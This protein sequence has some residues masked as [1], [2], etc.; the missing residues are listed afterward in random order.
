MP[1]YPRN[2][3][4]GRSL[5]AALV[6]ASCF[7]TAAVA[8]WLL[9][10]P[11]FS[12]AVYA[13]AVCLGVI[14]TFATLYYVDAYSVHVLASGRKTF[15]SVV[16][17][18]GVACLVTLLAHHFVPVP[19]GAASTAT[20]V[21]AL[22]FPL[23]LAGRLAFRSIS[24][25]RALTKR[26]LVIGA[27]ELGI[28]IAREMEENHSLGTELVGFLSDE[29]IYERST[30]EGLPVLGKLHH[31]E[32]VVDEEK[33]DHIVVASKNRGEHFPADQ[34][35][36]KKF[37]GLSIESGVSF[38]ERIS[39][40]V[41]MRDLRPSYL[42]FSEGFRVS[43]LS[44]LIKRTLDI[45]FSLTGLILSAPILA[46]CT[47]AICI[48]SRG[49]AFYGQ[50]R[51]GK[52]GKV[53]SVLKLRTM[54]PDA[55]ADTGPVW[56]REEDDRVTRVGRFLRMTRLDEVPQLW[57]V[58]K[59][60]MTLVG[61]RP[62][63]PEFVD[64]LSE[65]YPYF[66]LR[67]TLKPGITGWAQIRRGYVNEVEGFEEKLALDIYYMKYRSTLMDLLILWKTAKTVVLMSG[68]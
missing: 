55:E 17:L 19:K 36:I 45:A 28:E 39:G 23:L 1:H 24:A 9:L 33:I 3:Y 35:L 50:R 8:I 65:R 26:V 34:L 25:S 20:D 13:A 41:W 4:L 29:L 18:M 2:H 53:F 32:K 46:L 31:V 63:R 12:P 58:L 21:A 66:T 11:P 52:D 42:I 59:G 54:R 6:D 64:S 16:A 7:I 68:V 15:E 5:A 43:R 14:G 60:D 38:Y 49:S 51:V 30:I 67:S 61:P 47:V 37:R 62:E 27:S 22:Y 56:T 57:N 48:D 10:S 44:S 40:R